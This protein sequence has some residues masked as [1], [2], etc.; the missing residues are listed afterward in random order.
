MSEE[1]RNL[2]TIQ[3]IEKGELSLPG[4]L[5][6]LNVL[7]NQ[8]PPKAWIKQNKFADNAEYVPIDKIEFMLTRIFT[9]WFFEIKEVKLIGNSVEVNGTLYYKPII[10][11][12]SD[13]ITELEKSGKQEILLVELYKIKYSRKREDWY[14]KQDGTGAKNLQ[15][16]KGEKASDFDKIKSYSVSIAAPIAKSLAIKDAADEI[17]RVFGKDLNRKDIVGYDSLLNDKRFENVK[18][19][20]K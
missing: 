9:D 17:G 14:L 15:V 16:E 12:L 6:A 13:K 18:A 2:P 7:L 20:E 11:E 8:N 1:T 3:E 19:T 10:D 4:K 5:N